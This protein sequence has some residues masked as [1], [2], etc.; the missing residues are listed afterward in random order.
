MIIEIT[1]R[2]IDPQKQTFSKQ[3]QY[4]HVNQLRE[5]KREDIIYQLGKQVLAFV[6]NIEEIKQEA[7]G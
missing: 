4:I 5:M 2:A 6:E 7:Q 1:L 3:L